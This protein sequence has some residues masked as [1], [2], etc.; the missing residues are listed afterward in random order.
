VR[1]R[2]RTCSASAWTSE[3]NVSRN[4]GRSGRI[5]EHLQASFR[6]EPLELSA[7]GRTGVVRGGE[8]AD[9]AVGPGGMADAADVPLRPVPNHAGAFEQPTG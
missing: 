8:F 3:S 7:Q 4:S 5:V 2:R 9:V 6:A 1:P